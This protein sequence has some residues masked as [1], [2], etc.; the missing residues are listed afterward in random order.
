[1]LLGTEMEGEAYGRAAIEPY[2]HSMMLICLFQNL[3][4]IFLS[5]GSLSSILTKT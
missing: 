4:A 2:S 3:I 1:M 5:I